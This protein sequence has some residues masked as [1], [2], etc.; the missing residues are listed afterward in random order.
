MLSVCKSPP[1][2]LF[3]RVVQKRSE[4]GKED[5]SGADYS[6]CLAINLLEFGPRMSLIVYCALSND[7]VRDLQTPHFC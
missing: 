5:V 7:F 1:W 3:K 2:H 4:V 6:T